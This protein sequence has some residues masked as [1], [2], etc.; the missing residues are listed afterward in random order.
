MFIDLAADTVLPNGKRAE[1]WEGRPRLKDGDFLILARNDN[2]Y[3]VTQDANTGV[4][5]DVYV[6]FEGRSVQR[7]LDQ[8]TRLDGVM[9]GPV[10]PG[11]VLLPGVLHA[12][13]VPAADLA[14]YMK[15]GDGRKGRG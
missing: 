12:Y 8:P 9:V 5:F 3:S 1:K 7:D 11:F 10:P 6:D 14:G 2:D 4:Q 15:P 13:R